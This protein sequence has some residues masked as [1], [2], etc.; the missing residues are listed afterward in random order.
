M[1][2]FGFG[3]SLQLELLC[4]SLMLVGKLKMTGLRC[5]ILFVRVL[6]GDSGIKPVM[7][8]EFVSTKRA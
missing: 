7:V 3:P 5:K 4:V 2:L 6:V 1:A 8:F